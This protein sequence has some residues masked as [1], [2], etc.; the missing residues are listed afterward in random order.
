MNKP[1]LDACCGAKM[2][3]FDRSNPLVLFMDNRKGDFSCH[4]RE[5]LVTPDLVGDFRDMP[6]DD[7]TFSLV[8]FDPPHLKNVGK[9]SYMAAKYGRL[10]ENWRDDLRRGFSECWRVL[11]QGGTMVFKWS[12]VQIKLSEIKNM[13]PAEPICGNRMPKNSGT[14]WLVFY[15]PTRVEE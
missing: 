5:I 3:Y 2:F 13:F 4:G 9:T 8:I 10:S 14:H 15:K 6:F 12:E 11:K 1:I 7:E